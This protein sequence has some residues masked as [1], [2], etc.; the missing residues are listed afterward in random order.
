MRGPGS[1]WLLALGLL[2]LAGCVEP[3]EVQAHEHAHDADAH[4][5]H[6]H[7]AGEAMHEH[8]AAH[9]F[10]VPMGF[11]A[12]QAPGLRHEPPFP[13]ETG[14][15]PSE[16]EAQDFADQYNSV[17]VK[18]NEGL[19]KL[20]AEGYLQGAGTK[21]DPYVLERFYVERDVSIESTDRALIIREGFVKGTLRLNYVGEALYV[22]HV[23]ATDLRI[24]ENIKR[25]GPNTGGLFHDDAFAVVGQIRHFVGEF[26]NNE[27]GPRP[28]SGV[29]DALGDSGVFPVPAGVVFNLDGFHTADIHHN[30]FIG[31]V[32]AKLHGHNHGDCFTCPVHDHSNATLDAERMAGHEHAY[33]DEAD[34]DVL[35]LKTHHSVRY[36]SLAFH[37]NEIRVE[38]GYAL[39]Y[40]DR[41]HAGDDRTANSEANESLNDPHVHFE[42]V[43][44]AHNRLMGGGFQMD[45]FNAE[46]EKH[47]VPSL[48][49]VRFIGNEVT[50]DYEPTKP[51]GAGSATLTGL[52]FDAAQGLELRVRDNVVR[53]A[54][55]RS[56][57]QDSA[58]LDPMRAPA[59]I[60]G[61]QL[62]GFK[63]SNVTIAGNRVESGTYGVFASRLTATVHWQLVHNTF[64]TD[65]A[66]R[67]RD[68]SEPP[69]EEP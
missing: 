16:A 43:T 29:Q 49:V 61:L 23:Y 24:N 59:Q 63:T 64:Q 62:D 6:D 44:F 66:W 65:H 54:E 26:R 67:G 3:G 34:M 32:V 47:V 45:V 17:R 13:L 52:L 4:A 35:G 40:N 69:H 28:A 10:R 22:H 39:R 37:D 21:E 8:G 46:D 20:R 31:A 18:G 9:S 19:D 56:G 7:G 68:V 42:D 12:E 53:F 50:V 38:G 30:V 25:S 27:V 55:R 48:G 2:P 36:S 1:L 11:D 57:A 14:Q 51:M 60:I 15:R 33:T 58:L 41:N 5:G